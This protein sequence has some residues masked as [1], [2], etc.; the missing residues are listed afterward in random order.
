MS[1]VNSSGIA[2][3]K[4][5]QEQLGQTTDEKLREAVQ[6]GKTGK[7]IDSANSKN[8]LLSKITFPR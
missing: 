1:T 6:D 2:L 7:E 8:N 5:A 3:L 4:W